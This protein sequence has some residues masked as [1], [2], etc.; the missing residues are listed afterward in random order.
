MRLSRVLDLCTHP[1][2]HLGRLELGKQLVHR[3]VLV[4]FQIK[5]GLDLLTPHDT[6]QTVQEL[7]SLVTI[8]VNR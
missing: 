3:A 4:L 7:D 8:T 5:N 2:F 1:T 6:I